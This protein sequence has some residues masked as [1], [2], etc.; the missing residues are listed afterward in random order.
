[1][2]SSLITSD[3]PKSKHVMSL[4]CSSVKHKQGQTEEQQN[5]RRKSRSGDDWLP[6]GDGGW[7]IQFSDW[8]LYFTESGL[9][10]EV[11]SCLSI[12]WKIISC[13]KPIS[14]CLWTHWEVFFF[15]TTGF[16]SL[17]ENDCEPL[18]E[19]LPISRLQPSTH[20]SDRPPQAPVIWGQLIQRE[21][22]REREW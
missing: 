9:G 18:D 10:W 11:F 14:F 16:G 17:G 15:F 19:G 2:S 6:S 20:V 12:Q 1:M 21:R 5:H 8:L 22:E 7:L 3:S 4:M 13:K